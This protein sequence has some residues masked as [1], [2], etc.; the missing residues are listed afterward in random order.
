MPTWLGRGLMTQGVGGKEHMEFPPAMHCYT[1][2][3]Q[4]LPGSGHEPEPKLA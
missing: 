3:Q 4:T 2:Y 1:P